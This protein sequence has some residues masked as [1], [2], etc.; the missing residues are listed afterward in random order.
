MTIGR[1]SFIGAGSM[2]NKDV[3]PETLAYGVPARQHGWMCECGEMLE[4]VDG[5]AHCP[6]QGTSYVLEHG[7]VRRV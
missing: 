4:F 7:Q 6:R 5:K 2:V 3:P 1:N